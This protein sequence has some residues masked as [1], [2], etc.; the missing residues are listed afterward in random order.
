MAFLKDLT[1][2]HVYIA[3]ASI[4]G[5]LFLVRMLL[6]FLGG[7]FGGSDGAD[8]VDG[9]GDVHDVHHGGMQDSDVGF[10]VLSLQ[11]VTAFFMMFGL[12][13]LAIL[14]GTSTSAPWNL[15]SIGGGTAAGLGTV[16]VI[17][18]L[19][20][21]MKS[22]QYAETLNMEDASGQEG[23]VYLTIPAE[24]TGKIQ[25]MVRGSIG[26]YDAVSEGDKEI[27]TGERVMVVRVV[28]DNVLVV[29]PA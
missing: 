24:G 14:K 26:V 23:T 25:V 13:G 16:W 2:E 1:L 17:A 6:M 3:C 12:V 18:K 22:L 21:M 19:F 9:A 15:L 11:G 7:E 27:K 5:A 4:G 20:M 10:K 29:T 28:S 8:G